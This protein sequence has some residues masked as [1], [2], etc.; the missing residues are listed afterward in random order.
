MSLYGTRH[1]GITIGLNKPVKSHRAQMSLDHCGNPANRASPLRMPR[2]L[3]ISAL[4]IV[5]EIGQNSCLSGLVRMIQSDH[6][7]LPRC[8]YLYWVYCCE[9]K[10]IIS[11]TV[12]LRC[13]DG[14]SRHWQTS[15]VLGVVAMFLVR[16]RGPDKVGL[17]ASPIGGR[18]R[19]NR[20]NPHDAAKRGT[21]MKPGNTRDRSPKSE[22]NLLFLF[23]LLTP[24][25][26][27]L[28]Q[29]DTYQ[30]KKG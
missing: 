10:V 20:H 23:C 1:V 25:G 7:C 30:T 16:Q 14:C 19:W 27:V 13:S 12:S 6:H 18:N 2:S 28:I 26:S 15:S 3:S 29:T 9:G 8:M 5:D 4:R 22:D 24:E 21:T 11:P 17:Q